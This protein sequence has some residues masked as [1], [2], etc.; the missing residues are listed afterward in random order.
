M[1]LGRHSCNVGPE[2]YQASAEP[3]PP[4]AQGQAR[5]SCSYEQA[6]Y[7]WSL[8]VSERNLGE[9]PPRDVVSHCC[10]EAFR[11]LF[12]TQV[13]FGALCTM[14]PSLLTREDESRPRLGS[15]SP[16]EVILV[17]RFSLSILQLGIRLRNLRV[18]DLEKLRVGSGCL[19]LGRNLESLDFLW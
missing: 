8:V 13:Y 5:W 15:R 4:V 11:A 17:R 7:P 14:C 19:G 2:L 6:T 18:R 12:G 9:C 1:C 3:P 16:S 10:F